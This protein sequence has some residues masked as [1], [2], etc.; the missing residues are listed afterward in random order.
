MDMVFPKPVVVVEGLIVTTDSQCSPAHLSALIEQTWG[1]S[2]T[3]VPY[4]TRET[5]DVSTMCMPGG[6]TCDLKEC[7]EEGCERD[8]DALDNRPYVIELEEGVQWEQVLVA[9][10]L[11]RK[12]NL[13]R[14]DAAQEE[15]CLVTLQQV[16]DRELPTESI[17]EHPVLASFMSDKGFAFSKM[18]FDNYFYED[19]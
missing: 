7:W 2:F 3:R 11:S 16:H 13:F 9:S 8:I 17:F 18:Y 4:G 10:T 14:L 5:L 12:V 6:D 1:S 19:S 15:V